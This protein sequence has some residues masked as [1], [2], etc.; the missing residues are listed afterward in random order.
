MRLEQFLSQYSSKI[1]WAKLRLIAV[2]AMLEALEPRQHARTI[3]P[4]SLDYL[5]FRSIQHWA[6]QRVERFDARCSKEPLDRRRRTLGR[7]N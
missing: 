3:E 2:E 5:P 1:I 4:A 7:Q 6:G